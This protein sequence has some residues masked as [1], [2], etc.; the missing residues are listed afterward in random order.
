MHKSTRQSLAGMG[1][2]NPSSANRAAPPPSNQNSASAAMM[3]AAPTSA[4]PKADETRPAIWPATLTRTVDCHLFAA[5]P[6]V[7]LLA[8]EA[9]ESCRAAAGPRSMLAATAVATSTA[10]STWGTRFTCNTDARASPRQ[11]GT[12]ATA[13]DSDI[14]DMLCRGETS[15]DFAG[16]GRGLDFAKAEAHPAYISI[17]ASARMLF[18]LR[19]THK[20]RHKQSAS[21]AGKA[22]NG[23]IDPARLVAGRVR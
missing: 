16:S 18:S 14:V 4:A 3:S 15:A 13:D 6:G 21:F 19:A 11:R 22:D 2:G 20:A 1:A 12:T 23:T 17:A 8:C 9:D 5:L 10:P 7:C